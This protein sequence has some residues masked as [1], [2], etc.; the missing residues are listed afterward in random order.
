MDLSLKSMADESLMPV[1][2]QN[3]VLVVPMP[4]KYT[5]Q[6]FTFDLPASTSGY[7]STYRNHVYETFSCVWDQKK[8]R[9]H[10]TVYKEN[11]RIDTENQTTDLENQQSISNR[12]RAQVVSMLYNTQQNNK[13]LKEV[14]LLINI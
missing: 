1:P 12:W 3:T 10:A 5:L 7:G 6:S 4:K 14:H 2:L 8:Q 9:S 13:V 11:Q